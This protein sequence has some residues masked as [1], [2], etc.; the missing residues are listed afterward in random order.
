MT[1]NSRLYYYGTHDDVRL[2]DIIEVRRFFG[3]KRVTVVYIP[4]LS[5]KNR[6]FE[7]E[8]IRQWAIRDEYGTVYPILY[9][10]ETYQPP[11]K[12][13]LLA[14]GPEVSLSPNEMFE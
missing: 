7:Y 10:P 5:P 13:C 4:G 11:K 1:T 9:S 3:K 2:G 8:G 14:R 12:F 6:G